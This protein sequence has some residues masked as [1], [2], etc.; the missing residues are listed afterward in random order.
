MK[1]VFILLKNYVCVGKKLE[2]SQVCM[3]ICVIHTFLIE[4]LFS[5]I[6]V[7]VK[8]LIDDLVFTN[9]GRGKKIN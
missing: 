6:K 3:Y 4:D 2:I 1:V 5:Q 7:E 9:K 8:R